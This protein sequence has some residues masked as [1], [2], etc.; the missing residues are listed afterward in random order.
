MS[1]EQKHFINALCDLALKSGQVLVEKRAH[2]EI[3]L[4]LRAVQS[5]VIGQI[6]LNDHPIQNT[7]GGIVRIP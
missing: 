7:Y 2:E 3:L 5:I 4:H 6:Y 1:D